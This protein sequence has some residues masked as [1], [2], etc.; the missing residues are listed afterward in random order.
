MKHYCEYVMSCKHLDQKQTRK[1]FD[2]VFCRSYFTKCLNVSQVPGLASRKSLTG[3]TSK[4][5]ERMP[6]MK[7]YLEPDISFIFED[8]NQ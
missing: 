1:R 3:G 2:K 7:R 6:L 8:L 4:V 5:C